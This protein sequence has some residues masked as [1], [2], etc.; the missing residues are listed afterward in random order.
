ME[1]LETREREQTDLLD[2][3]R[4]PAP[5]SGIV[6]QK[7]TEA[8]E[9]VATGTQVIELIDHH[10]L[11]FEVRAPQEMFARAATD[12][13]VSLTLDAYPDTE[14]AATI[15]RR[16]AANDAISRTFLIRLNFDD[17]ERLAAYGMSGRAT[18][19]FLNDEKSIQVP[20]DAIVRQPDGSAKVWLAADDG[21]GQSIARSVVIMPGAA[22]DGGVAIE[23]DVAEG[24][25]VV[26]R[27]NEVLREG[28]AI[29]F[30]R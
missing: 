16:V 6:S 27:G 4:L 17:P 5:F 1:L 28:Q 9:W 24:D 7:F 19:S 3:H 13:S 25:L 12:T 11:V 15:E 8:G 20:R 10:A 2:R 21:S 18:F 23:G 30:N 14:F 22:F 29:T 26:V